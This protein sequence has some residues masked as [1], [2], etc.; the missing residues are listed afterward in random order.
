M[1]FYFCLTGNKPDLKAKLRHLPS[2]SPIPQ[3]LKKDISSPDDIRTLV[4]S[5]Y[6]K[7]KTDERIGFIFND[8]AKVD[9]AKHLPRMYA[10]WDFLLLDMDTYRGNPIEPHSAL[11][12]KI[13]LTAE[14]FDRWLELF[15][16]T[17]DEHFEGA[18]AEN[19]KFRAFSISEIWKSKFSM[20]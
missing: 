13:R 8:I 4:D 16:A 1:I 17:I 3:I 11:H 18:K 6:E 9:W 19:A 15:Q 12:Q 5:F 20:L 14:H 10:F 7:V 2:N